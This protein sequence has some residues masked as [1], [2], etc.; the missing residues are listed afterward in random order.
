MQQVLIHEN[1]ANLKYDADKLDI[2]KFKN[3]PTNLSNLNSEEGKLDVDKLVPVPVDLSKLSNSVKN[4]VVEKDVYNSKIKNVED[5][6]PDITNLA[7]NT[8]LNAKRNEAKKTC[9][10]LLT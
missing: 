2:D 8:T 7:T 9:L 10:V 4:D 5:K 1:F 6:I 3:L